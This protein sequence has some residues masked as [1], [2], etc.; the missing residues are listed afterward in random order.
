[1]L[2]DF[3]FHFYLVSIRW[4][5]LNRQKWIYDISI[6]LNI[7]EL[8]YADMMPL[9]NCYSLFLWCTDII[10]RDPKK[11]VENL[12]TLSLKC[13]YRSRCESDLKRL[14]WWV[15]T[16]PYQPNV[17]TFSII[18]TGFIPGPDSPK[19]SPLLQRLGSK[20]GTR[21]NS[22]SSYMKLTTCMKC[23]RTWIL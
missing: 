18:L 6:L 11:G 7:R 13:K 1:M 16:W 8:L 21:F 2:W 23:V 19:K 5:C 10:F 20:L 17:G 9:L 4:P 12:V 15:R 22:P 3:L 14:F